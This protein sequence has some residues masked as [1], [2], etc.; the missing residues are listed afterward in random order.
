VADGLNVGD[1]TLFFL[2]DT[3]SLD[4]GFAKVDATGEHLLPA[5]AQLKEMTSNWQFT[6]Q[7]ASTAGIEGLEAGEEIEEGAHRAT[8][9]MREARGEAALLGE[10]LGIHLPRHVR[11]FIAEL[12]GVSEALS[13][14]FSATAILFIIEAVVQL[15]NKITE[16]VST[17]FIFTEEM[18]AS[19]A[20]LV[21]NNVELLKQA[22]A[23]KKAEEAVKNFGKTSEEVAGDKIKA[24]T[25]SITKNAAEIR[26]IQNNLYNV[27]KEDNSLGFTPKQISDM[28]NRFLLLTET[29]K[30][31]N[32]LLEQAQLE[33]QKIA[34]DNFKKHQTAMINLY[35][36]TGETVLALQEVQ[37]KAEVDAGI[38]RADKILKI[39]EDFAARRYNV[40][41]AALQRQITLE[42][43]FGGEGSADR[44]AALNQQL[45]KLDSERTAHFS[46]ELEKQRED[47]DKTLQQM[48]SDVKAAG[49]ID[50]VLPENARK[51]LELRD[52]ASKL[53]VTLRVDL[54]TAY[55]TAKKAKEAY[56]GAGG[57]DIAELKQFDNQIKE[58]KKNLDNFGK[59]LDTLKLRGETTFRALRQDIKQ[60][61]DVTHELSAAGI[62][63]FDSLSQSLQAAVASAILGQK[64][65]GR[66]LEEA[67]AQALAQLAAQA[68]VKA[69][70][71]TAEGF[72]ALAGFAY[73]PASQ[74]FQAAG[75]MGAVGAAAG[76]SAA[77]LS[78]GAGGGSSSQGYGQTN[79][80]T[81][82][83][84]NQAQVR[85]FG[86]G[87][88]VSSPTLAVVGE[89]P[90]EEEAILPLDHPDSMRKIGQAIARAGGTSRSGG[91]IHVHVAG[92][93][94]DDNLTKV[95]A[96]INKKVRN[97]GAELTASSALRTVKRSI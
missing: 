95:I 96:K 14:A 17:H 35:K 8:T 34:E 47:L 70:F 60:G 7:A 65:F 69:L 3:T 44:I 31:D 42:K 52:A 73:G 62:Q 90:N 12:P 39:E 54:A 58:A 11:T 89:R 28:Q 76:I 23:F 37:A 5:N 79:Q 92:M 53:G 41:R 30:T 19:T 87:G 46:Q 59:S 49:P 24:L 36:A 97:G 50:I 85:Q 33:H 38:G 9:S 48:K 94:S 82:N 13:A 75:I 40:Q 26:Q 27:N 1:A 66:A 78:G 86:G 88:L 68:L 32:A 83:T 45:N 20:A 74:Y 10:G 6:G 67:T 64:N 63:A 91:G 71:Y 81:S 25:D 22:E 2:A 77:A 4:S 43:E 51:I 84:S 29:I 93:I 61:V 55:D 72:A 21:L 80:N 57:K 18:K 56:E 15:T 16:F